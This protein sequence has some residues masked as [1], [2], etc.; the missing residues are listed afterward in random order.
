MELKPETP[1]K[2]RFAADNKSGI[3]YRQAVIKSIYP[4]LSQYRIEI[5]MP[6]GQKSMRLVDERSVFPIRSAA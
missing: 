2:V 3:S 4:A 6:D 5:E 1:V